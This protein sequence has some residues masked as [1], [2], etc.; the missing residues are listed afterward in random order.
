MTGFGIASRGWTVGDAAFTVEVEAR[1]VNG[2][3]LEVRVRQPWGAVVESSVRK[4][5]EA[6]CGRGRIDV[7]IA[8]TRA[9]ATT[10]SIA[11]APS[12]VLAIVGVDPL[13]LQAVI[14]AVAQTTNAARRAGLEVVA[15]TP[16]ELLRLSASTTRD[17]ATAS[18]PT[19]PDFLDV[20]A[21]EAV[22]ALAQFRVAEGEALR[23]VLAELLAELRRTLDRI[24]ELVNEEL[25][26]YAERLHRR[27]RDLCEGAGVA[28]PDPTRLAQELAIVAA[29]ADVA[30]ELAR[31]A[32]HLDRAAEVLAAPAS[33][34]Q[35]RT[36]EF[37]AQELLREFTT[38]GSK[39]ISHVGAQVVIDAKGTLERLREQVS[40][41]E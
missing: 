32:M 12:E 36:L 23:L 22:D 28:P 2:R 20:L 38:I 33:A 1:S 13:R 39:M 4:L 7:A 25:A 37:V 40:N 17:P 24:T 15:A 19:A 8:C 6:R 21:T 9:G 11:P 31:I 30:E 5:V 16:V 34:G 27:V 14:E 35:G 29:R 41:V 18:M 26:P 3:H 10:G